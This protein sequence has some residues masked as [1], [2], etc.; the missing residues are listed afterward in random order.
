MRYSIKYSSTLSAI[1]LATLAAPTS[2]TASSVDFPTTCLPEADAAV[3]QGLTHLHN[4]MYISAEAAFAIA[5]KADPDC[6]M[7]E[8][9][10]AM[11]NFHPLWPGGPTAEET[12]RGT[13]AAGRM[14]EKTP[15][16]ALE[17]AFAQAVAAFYATGHDSYPARK[18]A[19]AAAQDDAYSQN[20]ESI[21]AAAF[22]AL[23]RLATAPRGP[24][25]TDVNSAVGDLLDSLHEIAPDHPG[26]IHYAIH[27]YDNPPLKAR[28]LPYAEIYDKTAPDAAHALHMPAHI[29]TRTGD[30]AKS[31]DLNRRSAEAALEVSGDVIQNHYA[32]AI[33]YMVYGHLQIGEP[34]TAERLVA[35]MLAIENHQPGFGGAY[36]L[37]AS[38]VRVLLE[39]EK[40]TEAAALSPDMHSA[41]P[42]DNFPQTVAMRWFAKGLGAARS[43]D[44]ETARAA[45]TELQSLHGAM[46]ERGQDYWATL[47][48]AQILS[49]EAWIEL[50]EGN[51][52]L[53]VTHQTK[54]ADMEDKIG[55]SPVT[56]GHV[57]PARELLG[58]M[59]LELDQPDAAAEAY[60]STLAHSP[61]RARSVARLSK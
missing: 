54:A 47:T 57:L 34:E 10:I 43:G 52:A 40:W 55:K 61:N 28:G 32:H 26:V 25:G 39:Q 37:A 3:D 59:L 58:D 22:A 42:W 51:D 15:G 23:G 27:A 17:Q 46:Q 5:A 8:W 35:E 6:A 38:P 12:T 18:S 4:M 33:D 13:A 49:I 9:G 48:E 11:A 60:R 29:F 31:I 2:S 50:A 56:P 45:V 1:L 36:A 21:D 24:A 30:W 7:A 20:P 19:W 53:A 44:I 16:N 14:A 41:I